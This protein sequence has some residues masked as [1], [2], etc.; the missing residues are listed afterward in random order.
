MDGALVF[1]RGMPIGIS[2]ALVSFPTGA[3]VGVMFEVGGPHV[4]SRSVDPRKRS[5]TAAK[6]ALV[7]LSLR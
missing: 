6:G 7:G 3:H 1:G 4:K 5:V 2:L